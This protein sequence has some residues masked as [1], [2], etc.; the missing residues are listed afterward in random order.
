MSANADNI[1]WGGLVGL[2]RPGR[3]VMPPK[4]AGREAALDEMAVLLNDISKLGRAPAGDAVLY[5]PRGNGKTVLLSAFEKQCAEAGADV[6]SLTPG[7]IRTEA[8]L[9]AQLLYDDS[10]FGQFL[11]AIRTQAGADLGLGFAKVKWDRLNQAGRENYRRRHLVDLS[12]AAT[13]GNEACSASDIC[14][15]RRTWAAKECRGNLAL[16]PV[17]AVPVIQRLTAD[18]HGRQRIRITC[19][20]NKWDMWDAHPDRRP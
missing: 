19:Y 6:I 8:D 20:R 7:A 4:L 15:F 12:Q 5:G 16:P 18:A 2:F 10:L 14:V 3:G 1:D 17:E 11:E 13:I 9:A